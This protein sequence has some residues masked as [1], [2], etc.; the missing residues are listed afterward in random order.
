MGMKILWIKFVNWVKYLF[1]RPN[2]ALQKGVS[3]CLLCL[4]KIKKS[5]ISLPENFRLGTPQRTI[6]PA[7]VRIQAHS[8]SGFQGSLHLE[9]ACGDSCPELR[10]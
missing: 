9:S 3:L 4:G 5:H 8:I 6:S 10:I 2:K 1:R 7:G